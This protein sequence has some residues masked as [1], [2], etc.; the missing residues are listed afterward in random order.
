MELHAQS[1]QKRAAK[2]HLLAWF[3]FLRSTLAVPVIVRE[4][5]AQQKH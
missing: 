1:L 3:P 4:Q 2:F 5:P